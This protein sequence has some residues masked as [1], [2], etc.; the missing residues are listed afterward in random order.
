M[1]NFRVNSSYIWILEK[2][3]LKISPYYTSK[4]VKEPTTLM[5]GAKA[6][7]KSEEPTAPNS[8]TS[9]M[10]PPCFQ[11]LIQILLVSIGAHKE[12][13]EEIHEEKEMSRDTYFCKTTTSAG[14]WQAWCSQLPLN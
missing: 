8:K 9:W 1:K 11:A 4:A 3:G 2:I 5:M 13:A 12:E 10:N 14:Y 6:K 7:M